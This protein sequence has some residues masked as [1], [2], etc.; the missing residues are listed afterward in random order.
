MVLSN[1]LLSQFAKVT[2]D[3]NDK[4]TEKTVY[5]T[6]VKNDGKMYVRLDGSNIDTPIS[7]TADVAV[8][9]RVT[10]MIKNH[11]A[12][13]TGNL[14]NPSASRAVVDDVVVEVADKISVKELQAESAEIER[15]IAEKV[16]AGTLTAEELEAIN[17][18][19]DNLE[20][21]YAKISVLTSAYATIDRLYATNAKIRNLEADY[22]NFKRLTADNLDATNAT[23][24]NLDSKYA[25]IDFANIGEAA[26]EKIFGTTG[27][28]T[29][30]VISEGKVAGTLAAV[31]IV[32]DSI[33]GGTIKADK[34][35]VKGPNGLYYALNVTENGDTTV[36]ETY[37][38]EELQNGLLGS[39]IVAK[40]I[41]AEKIAVDD[42]VAF[43]AYLAGFNVKELRD[44]NDRYVTSAI[45][46]GVKQSVHNTTS[47]IY[48]DKDGQFAVGNS[49]EYLKFYLGDDG[50]YHFDIAAK[51]IRLSSS[52]KTVEEA[53]DE[54]TDIQVGARN[55]IRNS[56]NL[57]YVD[58]FFRSS[59]YTPETA[60]VGECLLGT[61]TLGK[62]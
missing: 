37:T 52:G 25:D 39:I 2:N 48:M 33:E 38:P 50:K 58:Y 15:L 47:G 18:M 49:S 30:L 9:D 14:S 20:A 35:V 34:L 16:E 31:K 56:K 42:L 53:I 4:P 21:K 17:A 45:Y 29:D 3:N 54:A 57:V 12:I 5:G 51:S 62:E 1:D 46:S 7:S 43:D 36:T 60:V 61:M 59:E 11:S 8:G 22:G 26:I 6:I 28:V 41:T 27:I 32:G 55:L 24:E 23:I 40:S 19:V 44:A 10:V 13:V